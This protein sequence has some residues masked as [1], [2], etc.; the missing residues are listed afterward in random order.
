MTNKIVDFGLHPA[1]LN[2]IK[3]LVEEAIPDNDL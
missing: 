1:S 3:L 2:L